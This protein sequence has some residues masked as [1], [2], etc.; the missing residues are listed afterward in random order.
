MKSKQPQKPSQAAL[1][2]KEVDIV[3]GFTM[4]MSADD[5]E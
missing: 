4:V 2:D 5:H 3:A 1:D